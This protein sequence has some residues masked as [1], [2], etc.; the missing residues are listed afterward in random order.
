M[1]KQLTTIKAELEAAHK[2]NETLREELDNF[3]GMCSLSTSISAA[4]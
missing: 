4:I 1:K 3:Q 2:M